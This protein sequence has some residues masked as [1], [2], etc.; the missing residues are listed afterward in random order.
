[1]DVEFLKKFLLTTLVF[2]GIDF[3]WLGIIAR[4]F[5]E[6]WLG[7]FERTVNIP[8]AILTYLVIP[9]GIA[10]FTLNKS[11]TNS[12]TFFLRGALF[13][14]IVYATYDLTN[15]ATL[16]GWS[17][18]MAIVDTLWGALLSGITVLIVSRI[19]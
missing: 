8:A 17:V 10:I 16:K 18:Q 13:G 19:L 6:K 7:S 4:K 1:M 11:G 2:V 15:L 14:A 3:V 9:L 12:L 5:Y